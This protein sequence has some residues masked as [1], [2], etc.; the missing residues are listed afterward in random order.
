MNT[1]LVH[2][3]KIKLKREGL[4]SVENLKLDFL[5]KKLTKITQDLESMILS[6]N[7]KKDTQS[8]AN[9]KIRSKKI[10]MYDFPIN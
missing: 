4:V 1:I 2:L 3:N 10:K 8:E 6:S 9:I 7:N 5:M